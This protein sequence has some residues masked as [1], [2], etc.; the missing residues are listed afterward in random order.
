LDNRPNN[1]SIVLP[2]ANNDKECKNKKIVVLHQNICS[3]TP[4]TTEL[5][6]LLCS[7]LKPVN[8]IC[9]TEHWQSELK[10]NCI[11]ITDFKLVSAFG[12]SSSEHGGSGIYVKNGLET[13]E[14]SCVAGISEKKIFAMSLIELPAN[15]LLIVCIHRS[16]MEEFDKFLS[17]LEMVIERLLKKGKILSLC[18]DW[19]IDF[20]SDNGNLNDLKDLLLSYNLIDTLQSPTQITKSTSTLIDVMIINRKYCMEPVTAVDLGLSDHHAQLL[21]VLFKNHI[22]VDQNVLK[23]Y[24]REKNIREFKSLLGK[25]SWQEVLS[26]TEINAKFKAFMDLV[27]YQFNI[28]FPLQLRH[29]K[30]PLWKGWI[31]QGIRMSS[32]R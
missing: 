15:K 30:K 4:K 26:E 23:R 17:K 19:N 31:T 18:G 6:V 27:L 20:L 29:R 13:K 12:R 14:I 7:E 10:L 24:F 25:R 16:P 1:K 22:D 2:I 9:L 11:N 21:P 32:N 28:A 8:V 5:E 3:L